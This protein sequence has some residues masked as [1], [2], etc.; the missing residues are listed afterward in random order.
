[1]PIINE[2]YKIYYIADNFASGLTDVSL[3]ILLPDNTSAGPFILT[4]SLLRAGVY[5]YDYTP[6]DDGQYYFEIDSVTTPKKVV[7]VLD[8][9]DSGG[10][11][12]VSYLPFAQFDNN[13]A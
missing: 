13:G 5:T 10:G 3:T 8:F 1:M 6:L 9:E 12:V 7:Q 4:E 11:G 2:L